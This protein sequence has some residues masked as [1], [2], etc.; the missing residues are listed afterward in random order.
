M[1]AAARNVLILLALAAIL[2]L[3]PG[4]GNASAAILQALVIAMLGAIGWLA[5]RLYREHHTELYSLGE[6]NRG[7]LYASAGLAVLTL[8]GTDKLWASGPGTVFWFGLLGLAGY[9]C[10][11]VF[12]ASRQY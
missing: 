9:G 10:Y 3:A 2:M 11:F 8:T 5:V 12:R 4:G 6:R 7:L 1:T